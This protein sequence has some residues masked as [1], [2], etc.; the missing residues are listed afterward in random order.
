MSRPGSPK[1]AAGAGRGQLTLLPLVPPE[2]ARLLRTPGGRAASVAVDREVERAG[3]VRWT[4]GPYDFRAA[5]PSLLLDKLPPTHSPDIPPGWNRLT[6]WKRTLLKK[7]VEVFTGRN[8]FALAV[9]G[10]ARA[11]ADRAKAQ[12]DSL[13]QRGY[14]T[15]TLTVRG[16]WRTVVGLGTPSVWETSM[17]LHR[18]NGYPVIP[19]STLKGLTRAWALHVVL[20]ALEPTTP[21]LALLSLLDAYVAAEDPR[22]QEKAWER[23][24]RRAGPQAPAARELADRVRRVFGAVG[25]RGRV[26]FFDAVPLRWSLEVD[27]ITLHHPAYY[28]VAVAGKRKNEPNPVPF[29]VLGADARFLCPVAA[30]APELLEDACGWLESALRRFGVGAKTRAGYGWMEAVQGPPR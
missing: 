16:V 28:K 9:S 27:T 14:A 22:D 6:V 29:L 18:I 7:L 24:V 2:T 3:R 11:A 1:G 10:S 30:V 8:P 25:A 19:G 5:N 23:V 21:D 17:T 13:Q 12:L 20:E 26:L 4:E 15:R